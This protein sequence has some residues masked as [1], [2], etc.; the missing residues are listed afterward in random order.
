MLNDGASNCVRY[1]CMAVT[2]GEPSPVN[3]SYPTVAL[4]PLLLPEVIS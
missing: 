4:Y 1:A 3:R 2:F